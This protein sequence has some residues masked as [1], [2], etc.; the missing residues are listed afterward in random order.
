[1]KL[2]ISRDGFHHLSHQIPKYQ[3]TESDEGG[4]DFTKVLGTIRRQSWIIA[5][6]TILFATIGGIKATTD[7]PIYRAQ[8]EL[9]AEPLSLESQVISSTTPESLSNRQDLVGVVPNEAKLKILKSPRV[10]QPLVEELQQ[11]YPE[12]SYGS[13]ANNLNLN[14]NVKDNIVLVQYQNNNPQQVQDVLSRVADAYLQF[15]LEVRQSEFNKG[16]TFVE[17]Q[18]PRLRSRVDEIQN[19]LQTL[20]QDNNFIDPTMEAQ[21]LSEQIGMFVEQRLEV[22]AQLN[23]VKLLAQ[24][25]N[26]EL[27]EQPVEQVAASAL[28]NSRY[29]ALLNELQQIDTQIAQQSV[30]F[31]ETSP[32]LETLREQRQNLIPLL[33][34]EA[35]RVHRGVESEIRELQARDRAIS[36]TI[37]GLNQRIK[38]LSEITR[39]YTD[40]QRE[41]EIATKNLNQFLTKREALSIDMA[42]SE[43]PW[44]LLTAPNQPIASSAS[45]KRNLVLGTGI[46]LLLGIG[47]ALALDRFRDLLY[48]TREIQEAAGL[49]FLGTIPFDQALAKAD[50]SNLG[51]LPASLKLLHRNSTFENLASPS[52]E[53]FRALYTNFRLLNPDAPVRSIV[54][55]SAIPGEGKSTVAFHLAKAAAAM[56]RHVLLVDTDL[57]SPNLH[58]SMEFLGLTDLINQPDLEVNQIIQQSQLE[59]SL[60]ILPSGQIPPDPSKL[61]ASERMQHIM[62]KLQS[63]FELVIYDTTILNGFPDAHLLA[64]TTNGMVL[65]TGIGKLKRSLLEETME[66]LKVS[67]TPVLGMVVNGDKHLSL[68]LYQ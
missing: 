8:F 59:E 5:G 42:Q 26:K 58:R 40:L 36:Q 44:E 51:I 53:S 64:T 11:P 27:S 1:M 46:G 65:V 67:H 24:D 6:T 19:R 45:V 32:Q 35:Q 38:Q 39:Q 37:T 63:Q 66:N 3:T 33:E 41:L 47:T 68:N 4:L 54:I 28:S 21:Q 12:M 17:K 25:L 29:Q 34:A 50:D 23:E 22:K 62:E 56:G 14:V 15:S 55:S 30:T 48:T 61:L 2:D 9:L 20:R 18:L 49:P 31:A 10:L 60:F 43:S 13:L 52:I 7:T 57:R 16:L